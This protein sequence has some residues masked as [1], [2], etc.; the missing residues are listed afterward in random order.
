MCFVPLTRCDPYVTDTFLRCCL[1][2]RFPSGCRLTQIQVFPGVFR[3]ILPHLSH[4]GRNSVLGTRQRQQE[5]LWQYFRSGLGMR[6]TGSFSCAWVK[7]PKS[8]KNK[9]KKDKKNWLLE[10]KCLYIQHLEIRTTVSILSISETSWVRR[11]LTML[12]YLF[13]A[14]PSAKTADTPPH[15]FKFNVWYLNWSW[16]HSFVHVFS[17]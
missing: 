5:K 17:K 13:L 14:N 10:G 9:K 16:N 8:S 6:N 7:K 15:H 11:M 2:C 1:S 12:K 3:N 4:T